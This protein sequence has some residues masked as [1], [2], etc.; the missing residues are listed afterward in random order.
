MTRCATVLLVLAVLAACTSGGGAH[1]HSTPAAEAAMSTIAVPSVLPSAEVID[2]GRFTGTWFGHGRT[3]K[4]GAAGTGVL[5]YVDSARG[6]SYTTTFHITKVAGSRAAIVIDSYRVAYVGGY[7]PKQL[8]PPSHAGQLSALHLHPDD[9]M[10]VDLP[11]A[12]NGQLVC[13]TNA[14]SGACGA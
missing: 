1:A 7:H 8:D 5:T 6:P 13:G 9:T 3:L 2:V 14:A 10:L 4:I 11:D 12:T